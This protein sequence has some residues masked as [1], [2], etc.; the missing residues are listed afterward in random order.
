MIA[1]YSSHFASEKVMLSASRGWKIP[2]KHTSLFNKVKDKD[3][4]ILYGILRGCG[5]VI[6]TNFKNGIDY[7]HID[8]G[9]IKPKHFDGYFRVSLNDTQAHYKDVDLPADRFKKL[10]IKLED[11]RDNDSGLILIL[12]P[13][14]AFA[15]FYG[16]D[17][18]KW[19]SNIV[20]KLNG[21]PYKIR[22]KNDPNN[23]KLE[24]DLKY[25]KCV[26][27]FNSNAALEA[28][29]FGV[30]AIVVS[31][32]SVI[33]EWN[34]LTLNNINDCYDK[35]IKLDRNKLLNFVS[36]HQFTLDEME[37]GIA[38]VIIKEMRKEN[39]Y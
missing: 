20:A 15:I 32:H 7:L 23:I 4:A 21:R 30:P 10:N 35:S 38:P 16:I 29:I 13:S 9:Y 27:A 1:W 11:W 39:V 19:I 12:P 34:N 8:N 33:R 14:E 31:N 2:A 25:A 5:D 17:I 3:E 24:E 36:Y 26:I 22:E 6:H 28:T 18:K 37:K